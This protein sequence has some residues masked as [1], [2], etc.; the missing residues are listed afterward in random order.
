[1]LISKQNFLK[2]GN[3]IKLERIYNIIVAVIIIAMLVLAFIAL[4]RPIS[5]PQYQI[6]VNLSHMANNPE[7][8][9][10]A[11]QLLNHQSINRAEYFKLMRAYQFENSKARHYPAMALED[12]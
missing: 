3:Q 11:H 2:L 6:I 10:M 5:T 12:E 8:Q 4:Q 9:K 7:T 1:M